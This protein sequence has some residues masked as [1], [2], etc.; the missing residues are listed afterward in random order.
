MLPIKPC[1]RRI[2]LSISC[3]SDSTSAA[4]AGAGE[5]LHDLV[6]DDRFEAE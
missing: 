3:F 2:Q 4:S 6:S 1:A 5:D